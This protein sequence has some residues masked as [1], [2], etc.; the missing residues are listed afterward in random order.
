MNKVWTKSKMYS[1]QKF[2]FNVLSIP[3]KFYSKIFRID[4]GV[5]KNVLKTHEKQSKK[6]SKTMKI[7]CIK[8]QFNKNWFSFPY[9]LKILKIHLRNGQYFPFKL[10]PKSKINFKTLYKNITFYVKGDLPYYKQM[11]III[12]LFSWNI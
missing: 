9:F 3:V 6:R 5:S 7:T 8:I 12:L 1:I 4:T 2:R 11:N 10:F